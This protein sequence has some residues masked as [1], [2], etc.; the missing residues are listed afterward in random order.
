MSRH[1]FYLRI[2]FST[3]CGIACLLT[4]LLWV[5]SFWKEES[6]DH[7][8]FTE[9]RIYGISSTYGTI[10]LFYGTDIHLVKPGWS[11][12]WRVSSQWHD[13][14]G[15]TAEEK[16]IIRKHSSKQFRWRILPSGFYVK[17][18]YWLITLLIAASGVVPW[19]R[20]RFS[21]RTLLIATTLVAVVLGIIVWMTRAG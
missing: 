12:Q 4:C 13:N 3:T 19:F 6:L 20:W 2:A 1:P 10:R 14:P 18:P 9:G 17:A 15:L 11:P 8:T 7:R 16:E 21:L 5:R